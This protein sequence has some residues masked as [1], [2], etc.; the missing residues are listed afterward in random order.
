MQRC[1]ERLPVDIGVMMRS[2]SKVETR[3]NDDVQRADC[4]GRWEIGEDREQK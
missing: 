2:N 3:C 4:G 1:G